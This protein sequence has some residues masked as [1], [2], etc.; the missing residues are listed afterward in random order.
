MEGEARDVPKR[1]P[2]PNKLPRHEQVLTPG[3]ARRACGG[4]L[5]PIGEDVTEE[6]EY[7]PGRFIVNRIVRP[8][9]ACRCCDRITQAPLPSR[10]IERGW[11]D[12]GPL[13][14]VLALVSV[15]LALLS[16]YDEAKD[17]RQ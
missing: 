6:R 7:L 10:P 3:D 8:R 17:L 13:G 2:L 12:P 14:H 11:L 1:R 5:H 9:L 15:L 4:A 16:R